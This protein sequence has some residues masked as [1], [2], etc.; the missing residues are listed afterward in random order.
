M[1]KCQAFPAPQ[2]EPPPHLLGVVGGGHLTGSH[3][4]SAVLWFWGDACT[5]QVT[6]SP[7]RGWR[8]R[9][10]RCKA[11]V[12]LSH[13]ACAHRTSTLEGQLSRFQR[14]LPPGAIHQGGGPRAP[15]RLAVSSTETPKGT[16][17]PPAGVWHAPPPRSHTG[18]LY[19]GSQEGKGFLKIPPPSPPPQLAWPN[20]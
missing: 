9:V 2:Q 17:G 4:G 15:G 1:G 5:P 6:R 11:H 12:Q 3:S 14:P 20:G 16:E 7:V 8:H 13:R 10:A 19:F 18:P